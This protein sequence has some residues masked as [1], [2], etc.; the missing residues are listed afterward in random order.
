[1]GVD[2]CHRG[3]AWEVCELR[4]S[5]TSPRHAAVGPRPLVSVIIPFLNPGAF[6]E[7]AIL[8]VIAQTYPDWELLLVNDGSTDASAEIAR[9][10]VEKCSEKIFYLSHPGQQNCGV[11]TSRNLGLRNAKGTY[12]AFLDADDVWLPNKLERQLELMVAHPE[13]AM[14]YGQAI[15]WF[16]WTGKAE[17]QNKDCMERFSVTGIFSA[18]EL[19]GKYVRSAGV[20]PPVSA[21]LVRK[22]A[23]ETVGG[24]V[25]Q[26]RRPFYD[27]VAFYTKLAFRE[28][29]LID[30]EGYFRYRQHAESSVATVTRS[31]LTGHIQFQFLI[32]LSNY[33]AENDIV[34]IKVAQIIAQELL[35]A[36]AVRGS[37]GFLLHV[38]KAALPYSLRQ[39]LLLRI[40]RSR[41]LSSAIL[42]IAR[43]KLRA[44]R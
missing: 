13:V 35:R 14:T 6:L 3:M 29:I 5:P 37:A 36:A 22:Q 43:W 39:W 44:W 2:G 8:S 4:S 32:W 18:P 17:D 16:S 21:I 27:D 42:K 9:C 34:D 33:M 31:G 40:V 26:F 11:S 10:Y 20:V 41:S 12:I 24:F 15:I 30:D 25:E 38:A 7:E 1:M 19:A 23:A 28:R